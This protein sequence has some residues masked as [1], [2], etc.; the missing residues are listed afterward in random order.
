M[1][2]F[3]PFYPLWTQKIKIF[4]I[5][6]KHW[7]NRRYYHFTNVYHKWQSYDVMF[8]RYGVQ[9]TEFFCHFGPWN[10][11]KMKNVHGAIIILHMHTK[12]DDHI[13]LISSVTDRIFWKIKILNKWKNAGDIII[14][15][16][17]SINDNHMVCG[18]WDME[19]DR[20]NFL[21]FWTNFCTFN[22]LQTQKVKIWKK[23]K[24]CLEIL[25]FYT[26]AP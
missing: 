15:H 1:E 6:K 26:F 20:Q 3:L 14:L 10:N 21:L 9:Q 17:C 18:S 2:H 12:N 4:K 5:R 23:W 13:P 22:L 7:N 16:M 24:K 19:H 11:E 8:L 25:S